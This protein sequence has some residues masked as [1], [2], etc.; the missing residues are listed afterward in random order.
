MCSENNQSLFPG[1]SHGQRSLVGCSLWGH[2]ESDTRFSIKESRKSVRH[3]LKMIC[4]RWYSFFIIVFIYFWLCCVFVALQGL[5]LV[6]ASRGYYSLR[7]DNFSL[8][9]L[10]LLC[11]IG[12]RC[13]GFSGYSTWA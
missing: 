4:L 6:A 10:F 13:R 8:W 11:S 3:F 2:K 9:W 7:C 12:F 5:S 1:K